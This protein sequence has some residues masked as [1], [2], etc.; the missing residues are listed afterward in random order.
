MSRRFLKIRIRDLTQA[1]VSYGYRR[2]HILLQ[3]EGWEVNHK[4]VYRLYEQEEL[5]MRPKKPRRYVFACRRV[6]RVAVSHTNGN[7]SMDLMSDELYNGRRLRL[8]TLVDNFTLESLAIEVDR[9]L[10][11]RR[12]VEVLM[13]V[14]MKRGLP[15]KIRVD[16]G[17][18]LAHNSSATLGRTSFDTAF[19]V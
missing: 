2:L 7:W 10:G 3:T 15:G 17:P 14:V 9:S 6:E 4:R 8:L 13:E 11:G 1:R 19:D 12:V 16:N 18:R 5:M